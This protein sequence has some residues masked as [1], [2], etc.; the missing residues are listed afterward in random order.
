[1]PIYEYMCPQ[2]RTIKTEVKTIAERDIAPMCCGTMT[3]K[4]VSELSKPQILD[5]YDEGLG[6]HVTGL[7]DR[8]RKMKEKDLAEY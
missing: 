8:S 1:M 6:S 2:C 3:L 4:I 5:Y 7:K